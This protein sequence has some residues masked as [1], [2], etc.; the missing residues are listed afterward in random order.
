MRLFIRDAQPADADTISE[1]AFRSKGY[2]QY[3]ADAM[4]LWRDELCLD[5]ADINNPTHRVAIAIIDDEIVGYSHLVEI[6]PGV[7]ELDGL[8]VDPTFIGKGVGKALLQD[9]LESARVR[10]LDVLH[11][12]SDP[13]AEQFYARAGGIPNGVRESDKIAG[14]FLPLFQFQLK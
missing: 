10:T 4:E 6:E 11:V 8:F 13:N 14:R 9:V 5:P 3:P 7:G 12:E 2:W 1:L